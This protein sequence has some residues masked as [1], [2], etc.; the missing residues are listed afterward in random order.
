M[1]KIHLNSFCRIG[2][3]IRREKFG[4]DINDD[5]VRQKMEPNGKVVYLVQILKVVDMHNKGN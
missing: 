3:Q 5:Q 2:I 1:K 4:N